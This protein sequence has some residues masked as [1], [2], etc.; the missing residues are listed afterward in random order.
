MSF[1]PELLFAAAIAA[2]AFLVG[3]L[4]LYSRSKRTR[5]V[6]LKVAG[7]PRN[8]RFT[9]AG[10]SGRFTHSRQTLSGW[11]RGDRSFYCKACRTKSQ[12]KNKRV[13]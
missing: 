7:G 12:N 4:Y 8:L 3:M 5:S 13:R 10:C 1:S 11:E 9:C 6:G 2:A